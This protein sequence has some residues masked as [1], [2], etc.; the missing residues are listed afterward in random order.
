LGCEPVGF[1]PEQ[2]DGYLL[3]RS[4]PNFQP[5]PG[6]AASAAGSGLPDGTTRDVLAILCQLSRDHQVDWEISHDYSN[7]PIGYIRGGI[8]D[9]EVTA[10]LEAFADLGDTL[11]DF[12]ADS[13]DE[14]G[15]FPAS[16]SH[17]EDD[18][19]DDDD[20]GPPTLPFRKGE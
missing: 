3:G 1:L 6:D 18:V 2:D 20:D 11:A 10:Q 19:D 9:G 8:C 16:A 4:K 17:D 12:M 14:S 13:D 5:D 7:G 15:D